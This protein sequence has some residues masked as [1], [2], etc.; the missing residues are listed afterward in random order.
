MQNFIRVFDSALYIVRDHYDRYA[1]IAVQLFYQAVEFCG[2]NGVK[3]RHRLV[4]QEQLLC[5]AE[6]TRKQNP[7]LL[8]AR[9]LAVGSA[10]YIGYG[11]L[12]H[13]FVRQISVGAGIER[14]P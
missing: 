13:V 14:T 10:R 8:T 6:R 12:L 4:E 9:Q 7:L 2:H 5:G 11:E 1:G 3:P